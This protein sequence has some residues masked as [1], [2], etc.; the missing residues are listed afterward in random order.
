VGLPKENVIESEDEALEEELSSVLSEG[1]GVA[2][3]DE[4]SEALELV[5]ELS[6]ALLELSEELLDESSFE[7]SS[8]ELSLFE[9]TIALERPGF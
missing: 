8:E 2:L 4:V 1:V 5:D 6:V 9:V 3:A 7:L